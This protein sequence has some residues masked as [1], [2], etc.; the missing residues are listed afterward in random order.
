MLNSIPSLYLHFVGSCSRVLIPALVVPE[1]G[2]A[3]VSHPR[4]L[5]DR[6]RERL[7]LLLISNYLLVQNGVLDGDGSTPRDFFREFQIR[8]R[9]VAPGLSSCKRH[10][11]QYPATAFERCD[12][13]R[14]QPEAPDETRVL[15][16]AGA[17]SYEVVR[18]IFHEHRV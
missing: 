6:V 11:P 1:Y 10:G 12:D 9:I 16:V 17:L 15:F 4:E 14:S 13:Q 5:R 2:P 18:Y 7:P 3:L 8:T